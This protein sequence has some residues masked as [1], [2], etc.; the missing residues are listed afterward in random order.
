M[1]PIAE[2][3][4]GLPVPAEAEEVPAAPTEK[5]GTIEEV[6]QAA[7]PM[8]AAEEEEAA[9]AEE[10]EAP[11]AEEE[12]APAAEEEEEPAAEEEEPAAEE[13]EPAAEEEVEAVAE[14]APAD[15]E[16]PNIVVPEDAIILPSGPLGITFSG[17][18]PS[19]KKMSDTSAA[20]GLLNIGDTVEKLVIPGKMEVSGMTS[21]Q[22]GEALR[23][24]SDLDNRC[25]VV[26]AASEEIPE[27]A[28][29]IVLPAGS[30]GMVFTGT[31]ATIKKIK[32]DSPIKG[33]VY[34]GQTITKLI[35]PGKVAL[36]NM[37][38]AELGKELKANAELDTRTIIV[39]GEA[40]I[41]PKTKVPLPAG[42]IGITFNGSPPTIKKIKEDSPIAKDVAVGQQ[43]SKLMFGEEE[44]LV[45]P[46]AEELGMT[47]RENKD[48]D[49]RVLI[50]VGD[51]E[52][53]PVPP[54][55]KPKSLRELFYDL[56]SADSGVVLD[57]LTV[58]NKKAL[59]SASNK[60]ASSD[61][62]D[63]GAAQS[64]LAALR[65]HHTVVEIAT[66]CMQLL[67]TLSAV[68]NTEA[69]TNLYELTGSKNVIDTMKE[70]PEEKDLQT[71]G[72]SLLL[73][74]GITKAYSTQVVENDSIPTVVAAMNQF[75]EDDLI[76]KRGCQYMTQVGEADNDWR[77]QI[78][79]AKGLSA[80]SHVLQTFDGSTAAEAKKAM[81][82]HL[83]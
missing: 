24:Y 6:E 81:R 30:V 72:V 23:A 21:I 54:P 71:Y 33:Q 3:P 76:N 83:D 35:I 77:V 12:E 69:Q 73:N 27:G 44:K 70:F 47:L 39:E 78:R 11:A 15:D 49:N 2:D 56:C 41:P 51:P 8:E 75:D 65:N 46:T 18:P 40:I 14:D 36:S 55:V 50:M 28:T 62:I 80:V 13:E 43:V 25:L 64:V 7:E 57:S 66:G 58:L 1:P 42:A 26:S 37:T 63:K 45:N 38:S 20:K 59:L 34:P 22:L 5:P 79:Q 60:E 67:L 10:E 16:D 31:P 9:P 53:A 61:M 82:L 17:T 52:A 32:D 29:K 74:L 19:V 68:G 4:T 48:L